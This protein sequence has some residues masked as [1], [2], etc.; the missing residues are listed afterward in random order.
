MA[1]RQQE[2]RLTAD[3]ALRWGLV[4]LALALVVLLAWQLREVLVL[5]FLAVL[6][7]AGVHRLTAPLE[8]RGVPRIAAVVAVYLALL[9]VVAVLIWIVVPPLVEQLV[10]FVE[11]LPAFIGAAESWL[12]QQLD[13]LPGD[14]GEQGFDQ[15]QEQIGGVVPDLAG[16]AAVPLIVVGLLVNL[17][18]V[19]FLSA[20]LLLER[21]RLWEGFLGYL[22]PERR[23]RATEVAES[24]ADK[25]GAF[26]RGQLLMMTM[27][28]IGTAIGMFLF[29][30][31]FVLPLAFLAFLSEAIPIVGPFIAGVP[32]VIVAFTQDLWTGIF[33]TAWIVGLQQLEGLVLAPMIQNKALKLSPVVILLG[34][35]AGGT[36]A[37][38]IG[39]L[40]AIP[41]VAVA[42]VVLNEVVLPIRRESWGEAGD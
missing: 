12:R 27:I 18:L 8:R 40:I 1:Q 20:M 13:A 15:V 37:G 22:R 5:A 36:V 23:R 19:V 7:A 29:G 9:G 16:L 25:L 24:A 31:P 4:W 33:M 42:Q 11:E 41:L 30:V 39:A 14:I 32:I 35:L 34:V 38:V 28:G 6:V 2:R 17:V 26:V 10:A 3:S 21:D